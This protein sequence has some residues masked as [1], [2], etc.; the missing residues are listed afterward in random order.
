MPATGSEE[1][2]RLEGV[3]VAYGGVVAL[4]DVSF[5]LHKGG[6]LCVA[7]PNG[8]GKTTLLR[9]ILGL[10]RPRNGEIYVLGEKLDRRNAARLRRRMGYVPQ[11]D[12]AERDIPV[13]ME[14]IVLMGYLPQLR[15]P[16]TL[17]KA[18]FGNVL[19]LLRIDEL[20]GKPFSQL[21]GGQQQRVLIARALV[22][23]PEIL[24]LD[25][26]FSGVDPLSQRIILEALCSLK[27]NGTTIILVTHDINPLFRVA[28]LFLFL[29]GRVV[30]CGGADDVFN[31]ETLRRV[32]GANVRVFTT[33]G[34]KHA[35]IGDYHA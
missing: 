16:R 26:P 18:D 23:D 17:R 12:R 3:T 30:A 6:F 14:D 34:E 35:A 33:D 20:K 13:L 7:G 28:D 2:L 5:S 32:Y 22:G 27:E 15:P 25:E 19:E 24:L 31:E 21:S 11:L 29:K 10:L 1:A 9:T 8:A 4:E